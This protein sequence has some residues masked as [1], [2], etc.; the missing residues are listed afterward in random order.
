MLLVLWDSWIPQTGLQPGVLGVFIG[1]LTVCKSHPPSHLDVLQTLLCSLRPFYLNLTSPEDLFPKCTRLVKMSFYKPL[2]L[3]FLVEQGSPED[4]SMKAIL[5]QVLLNRWTLNQNYRFCQILEVFCSQS[6]VLTCFSNTPKSHS[7]KYSSIVQTLCWPQ[8]LQKTTISYC[9]LL[10][11]FS[12][13]VS[14]NGF[15]FQSSKQLQRGTQ[16]CWLV[17]HLG[18]SH[19]EGQTSYN[20]PVLP[21]ISKSFPLC[22]SSTY[23]K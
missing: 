5:V 8:V 11:T 16:G 4:P 18:Q 6:Q 7:L 2:M 14:I 3:N 10:L 15:D 23:S 19:L 9:R 1:S 12:G 13:F 17:E 20:T 21:K 22:F